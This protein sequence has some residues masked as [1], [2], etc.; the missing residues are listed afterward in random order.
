MAIV[1]QALLK[2]SI[3]I[4]L[5]LLTD[6]LECWIICLKHEFLFKIALR[7][8]TQYLLYSQAVGPLMQACKVRYTLLDALLF[9]FQKKRKNFTFQE[10]IFTKHLNETSA[11]IKPRLKRKWSNW[12]FLT[13]NLQRMQMDFCSMKKQLL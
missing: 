7:S 12:L 10:F 4:H 8:K 11:I 13:L 1:C 3:W 6:F 5:Y 2:G 9:P